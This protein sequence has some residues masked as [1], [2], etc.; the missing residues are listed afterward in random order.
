MFAVFKREYLSSVRK[1]MFI[2]MTLFFPVLMAALFFIP[3]M[4]MARTL[5]GKNVAVIDG[6]GQLRATFAKTNRKLSRDLPA[7]LNVEYVDASRQADL[8]AAAKPY[9]NRLSAGSHAVNP[10]DAILIVPQDAISG[11]KAKMTFYSRSATDVIT[12][13][14]LGATANHEIQRQRLA[15]RGIRADELDA[16]TR[17]VP[18]EGVQLSRTGEQKRGGEANFM[19]AFLLAGLLIIPAFVY[20]LE[21]MRGIVQEK[22]DRIVEVLISSMSPREL[23]TGKIAGV[24]AVGLTQVSV[25]L[26]ILVG[27]GAFGA[28][29]A[30]AAG[31]N[32]FQFLKPMIFVYFLIFFVLGY[33]TYVCV[34]AVAGAACNSDKEAQ[35]LM[36]PIQMVMMTPWFLMFPI[37]TN[38]D[39]SLAIG[40]SLSPVFGPVTMFA[41]TVASEPPMWHVLL[42]IFISIATIAVFFWGTAKIFRVGILSYG[43]RPTIPE[44]WRWLRVA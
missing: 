6:T 8:N 3:M 29:T 36:A 7:T 17:N 26:L 18:I 5:G 40:F 19:F 28:A 16:L 32:V 2:F 20:G 13:Q 44:L 34:Y 43:K 22:N 4:V 42:S 27:A 38:P 30:M 35:Q 41:R 11:D 1:K 23:L 37:I 24:A 14:I 9:L 12:Q 31:I 33:L 25:W 39:S 10:V 21:I 15:A